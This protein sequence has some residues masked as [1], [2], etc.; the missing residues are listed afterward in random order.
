MKKEKRENRKDEKERRALRFFQRMAEHRVAFASTIA[1]LFNPS[2][3]FILCI[4]DV[5]SPAIVQRS[6]S[7]GLSL[8]S[9]ERSGILLAERYPLILSLIRLK[10][11][12][13]KNFFYSYLKF[14]QVS[15]V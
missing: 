4:H 3:L 6:G 9:H 12:N 5:H 10:F 11:F 7:V 1:T 2:E 15:S 13:L 8:I 14:T